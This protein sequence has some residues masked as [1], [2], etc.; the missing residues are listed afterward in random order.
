MKKDD[1]NITYLL[2][3]VDDL[4]ICS[5]ASN[6]IEKVKNN[7]SEYFNVKD[8]GKINTF[9]G[10]R[11]DYNLNQGIM[12]LDQTTL[13]HKVAKKFNVE[14]C[15]PVLTPIEKDL[16]LI[17]HE[18]ESED[19]ILSNTYQQ[20][21]GCLMYIMLGTRP[22]LSFSI[23]YFSQFQNKVSQKH[24]NYLLRVLKYLVTTSTRKLTFT[25]SADENN[26]FTVYSDASWASC[27][28]SRRSVTGFCFMLHNNV[29][30]WKSKKQN[31]VALSSTESEFLSLCEALREFAWYT[32]ILADLSVKLPRP[33]IIHE[34]NQ[35]CISLLR[36][37]N[38]NSKRSKHIDVKYHF[39]KDMLESKLIDIKYVPSAFQVADGFTKALVKS[40][41]E[42]FVTV[43]GLQ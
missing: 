29:T 25:K 1:E 38:L 2:T 22:D 13:I 28:I 9:L 10:I 32:R 42:E 6:A 4:L 26:I 19:K 34:D 40:K 20:L 11:V 7:L 35:S 17:I 15:I 39:V 41:F 12:S 3:Y 33:V 24:Y 27:N 31:I 14:Q 37:P 23:T 21:L 30:L 43:I 16:N 5:N 18:N 36:K 8:L